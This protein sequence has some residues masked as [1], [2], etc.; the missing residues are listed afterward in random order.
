MSL[1]FGEEDRFVPPATIDAIETAHRGL[2][3]VEIYRYAGGKHGFA[4]SDSAA[5]DE[6]AARLSEERSLAMLARLK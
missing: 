2:T 4:Q 3:Y 5:Y 1:H 6:A